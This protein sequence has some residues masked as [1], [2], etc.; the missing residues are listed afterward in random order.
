MLAHGLILLELVYDT[1]SAVIR[2]PM[3]LLVNLSRVRVFTEAY[4][5]LTQFWFKV[6]H[7]NKTRSIAHAHSAIIR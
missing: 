2:I 5:C 1:F 4:A 6:K 3:N 7:A